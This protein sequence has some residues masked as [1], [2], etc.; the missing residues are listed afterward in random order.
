MCGE[1]TCA[2]GWLELHVDFC[3]QALAPAS[4]LF[5]GQLYILQMILM[6]LASWEIFCLE[7]CLFV[8]NW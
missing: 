7:F 3:V 4:A 6:T 5:K 1:S 2:E 8:T